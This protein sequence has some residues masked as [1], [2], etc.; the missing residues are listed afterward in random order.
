MFCVRKRNSR[1]INT[2]A[3]KIITKKMLFKKNCFGTK[4]LVEITKQS[5]YKAASFACSLATRDKPLAATLQRK[6]SGGIIFV[7]ITKNYYKNNCSKELFCN[8]FSQDG[9]ELPSKNHLT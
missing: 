2:I 1:G 9:I 3:A 6:C 5:H 4:N 8:H 7:I